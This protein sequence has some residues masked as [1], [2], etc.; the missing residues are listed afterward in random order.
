[1]HSDSA[2]SFEE[3]PSYFAELLCLCTL[4]QQC[5]GHSAFPCS[6][7]LLPPVSPFIVAMVVFVT[8]FPV[9]TA[10]TEDPH[11]QAL[12]PTFIHISLGEMSIQ[13]FCPFLVVVVV[14]IGLI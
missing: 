2:F 12:G 1:V 13:L 10:N 14:C 9:M 4:L 5:G 7:Q 3:L 8:G 11:P 6:L